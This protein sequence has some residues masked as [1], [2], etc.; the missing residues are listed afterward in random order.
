MDNNLK[1]TI[2]IDKL[3]KKIAELN[4]KLSKN[5]G[6]SDDINKL[7]QLLEEREKIFRG[8]SDEL[9]ALIEKYGSKK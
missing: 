5:E 1:L 4:I 6:N 8:T 7:N 9:K 2:V 3:D